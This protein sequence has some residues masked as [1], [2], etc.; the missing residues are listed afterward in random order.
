M[1][2]DV[3]LYCILSVNFSN[4]QS[5][6]WPLRIA[7][8]FTWSMMYAA[9]TTARI[10]KNTIIPEYEARSGA[11][12]VSQ[13]QPYVPADALIVEPTNC[14]G[15]VSIHPINRVGRIPRSKQVAA[16]IIIPILI[17]QFTS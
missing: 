5:Q 12:G 8:G 1:E 13:S 3:A 2:K 11:T 10:P 14:T 6:T 9:A 16:A 7:P 15:I 17:G 4:P